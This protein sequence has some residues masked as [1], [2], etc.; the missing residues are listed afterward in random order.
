MNFGDVW[1]DSKIKN[2]KDYMKVEEQSFRL[3][4]IEQA[5]RE[6]IST[7]KIARIPPIVLSDYLANL[8]AMRFGR[9]STSVSVFGLTPLP[10]TTEATIF[11]SLSFQNVLI[12]IE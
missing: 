3:S 8:Y 1:K 11:K 10:V 4:S 5:L 6:L 12:A 2:Y 9:Y 7:G